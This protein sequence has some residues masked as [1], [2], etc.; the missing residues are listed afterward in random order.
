MSTRRIKNIQY[1]SYD[2][3]EDEDSD[4]YY[5]DNYDEAAYKERAAK[6]KQE[7]AYNND[8]KILLS[9]K[10]FQTF[11]DTRKTQVFKE[12]KYN[13]NKTIQ[14]LKDLQNEKNAKL[15]KLK[16]KAVDKKMLDSS[17]EAMTK[18][19]TSLV[20]T[21]D[22]R[23]PLN[24]VVVG[25]VDAGKSTV[26]GH[27]LLQVGAV[28]SKKLRQFTKE[29]SAI[30]R[31][32]FEFAWFLD[33][34]EDERERGVS[35]DFCVKHFQST[36]K[37]VT[38]IDAPGHRDFVPNMLVGAVLADAAILVVDAAGFDSGFLQDGQTK[39][40]SQLVKS[41]G[42]QQL[43]VAVN[44]MDAV[45][46]S[47]EVFQDI[48]TRILKYL[49]DCGIADVIVV[50]ISGYQ[51]LNLTEAYKECDWW[52]GD[53]LLEAI[54]ELPRNL[55]NVSNNYCNFTACVSDSCKSSNSLLASI[56]I[57]SGAVHVGQKIVVLP[58][59]QTGVI[60][61]LCPYDNK[62][63]N[64]CTAGDY[65]DSCTISQIDPNHLSTGSILASPLKFQLPPI[66]SATIQTSVVTIA[67]QILAKFVVFE[68]DIPLAKG[69]QHLAHMHTGQCLVVI[70]SL[71]DS[72]YN[73]STGKAIVNSKPPRFLTSGQSAIVG[74]ILKEPMAVGV[75]SHDNDWC[76]SRIILRHSGRTVGAGII[77]AVN[78]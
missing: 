50:P 27:L 72:L 59:N 33:E 66:N 71:G 58:S 43:I 77:T 52:K 67:H 61:K 48:R 5:D 44:K 26:I 55:D 56:K 22:N 3:Y 38:I 35:V 39:E 51:G 29:S 75:E 57:T 34:G 36:Y 18:T 73:K 20:S 32:S 74:M 13:L 69:Q 7:E 4:F 11:A 21:V 8:L 23:S 64:V 37:L 1:D 70:S 49:K 30:G 24:L 62:E 12:C 46:W 45:K 76:L 28:T 47:K 14:A 17:P 25:H 19:P 31:G 63:T 53:T 41:L 2:D 78:N 40:H 42:I 60:K 15:C 9:N 68:V 16:A 65:V 6:N 54:D 10:D